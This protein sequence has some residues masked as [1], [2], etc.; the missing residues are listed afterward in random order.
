MSLKPFFAKLFAK[1][2]IDIKK[3]KTNLVEAAREYQDKYRSEIETGTQKRQLMLAEGKSKGI[4]VGLP[5]QLAED[6][7]FEN[8]SIFIPTNQTPILNY[9]YFLLR[10]TEFKDPDIE[11][12]RLPEH[13][14]RDIKLLKE[15]YESKY[16]TK[17]HKEHKNDLPEVISFIYNGIDDGDTFAMIK[18]LKTLSESGNDQEATAAFKKGRELCKQ[19]KLEWSKIPVNN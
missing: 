2:A 9:L 3:N 11:V 1:K 16:G 7:I 5:T 12:L 19:Y 6:K 4:G 17:I 13:L 14:G 15:E 10:E 8:N 18:K